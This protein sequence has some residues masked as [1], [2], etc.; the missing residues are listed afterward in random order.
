MKLT[1]LAKIK[2]YN[3]IDFLFPLFL[4]CI[5]CLS[6]SY[7]IRYCI[8]GIFLLGF[9]IN[10]IFQNK[11]LFI[12]KFTEGR[13]II[14]ISVISGVSL[15]FSIY[16]ETAIIYYFCFIIIEFSSI[17]LAYKTKSIE[18]GLYIYG[19]TILIINI[20]ALLFF[21][22]SA[23]HDMYEV[24]NF[25][26]IF[27]DKNTCA[28]I[29]LLPL[30]IFFK[31][32]VINKKYKN[33]IFFAL[34]MFLLILTHS[35]T[36]LILS[37][38]LLVLYLLPKKKLLAIVTLFPVSILFF[39]AY[40]LS[41]NWI[42]NSSL[43]MLIK[44]LIGKDL[45]LSGRTEI[46]EYCFEMIK[47]KWIIGY[48]YNAIWSNL[49]I[50]KQSVVSHGYSFLGGHAHNGYIELLLSA[51]VLGILLMAIIIAKSIIKLNKIYVFRA[52]SKI[53]LIIIIY[54]LYANFFMNMLFDYGIIWN[55]VI[56]IIIKLDKR[57]KCHQQIY[58]NNVRIKYDQTD[59]FCRLWKGNHIS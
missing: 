2:T 5:S 14:L 35:Y 34:N 36:A 52:T 22:K 56:M 9:S 4:I 13:L 59:V 6:S 17:N 21:K 43:N 1:I 11:K 45:T 30:L 55:L 37:V 3:W 16:F 58:S 49:D 18:D 23:F 44:S 28:S 38:L 20:I 7:W 53:E 47:E 46:W 8:F 54:W 39:V 19:I 25:R 50:T 48:G 42:K 27:Y 24:Q 31:K 41:L 26:G 10:I 57:S 33:I 29:M 15:P 32:A 40:L 12:S 51:G